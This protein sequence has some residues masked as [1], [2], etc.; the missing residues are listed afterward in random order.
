[1]I[2]FLI[3]RLFGFLERGVPG[4]AVP[5]EGVEENAV[6]LPVLLVIS[7]QLLRE[8]SQLFLL[9]LEHMDRIHILPVRKEDDDAH[10]RYSD[11]Q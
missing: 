6:T 7:L 3:C 4:R 8:L 5:L 2:D 11:H 10:D 1:M 9:L